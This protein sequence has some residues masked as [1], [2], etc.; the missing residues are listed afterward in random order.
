[1][2][3]RL[4]EWNSDEEEKGNGIEKDSEEEEEMVEELKTLQLSLHNK[5]GFT[6]NKSFK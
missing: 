4:C 5:E 1:M 6:S 2:S 3:L